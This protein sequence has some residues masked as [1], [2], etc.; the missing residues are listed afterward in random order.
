MAG[1]SKQGDFTEKIS[2][3]LKTKISLIEKEFGKDSNEYKALFLQYVKQDVENVLQTES[4][5]RH[6]EADLLIDSSENLHGVERLYT[7]CAVI[8]PT[9]I[10]AAH[11]RYCLRS[12]YDVF[13]LS[14]EE[15]L[16]IAKY[17]GSDSIRDSLSEV[18]ITGGDPLVVP[19]RLSYLI[20]ALIHEA[21]NI[22]R[23][24]IGTRLPLHDPN[25]VDKNIFDIFKRNSDKVRFEIATQINHKI[26]LFPESVAVLKKI[27]EHGVKVY[28]QNVIIKGVNDNINTLVNLYQMLRDLD[29][30]SHYLFHSVPMKG[31]HHLRTSVNRGIELAMQLTNSGKISGRAKPMFT[32]M[33]DIGKVTLYQGAIIDKTEDNYLLLKTHYSYADRIKINPNWK[34]PGTASIADDGTLRVLYL[35]GKD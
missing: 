34:L 19:K 29:I 2:P 3:F 30:E 11:C 10:C 12:N 23:I 17:C 16:N 27:R 35:D 13:T 33:T 32:L 15:L 25:R 1:I 6:W 20:E 21:P 9:M 18:L 8:E 24:R 28:S 14:E 26:E 31:T 5:Q 4:N 22:K 7:Q